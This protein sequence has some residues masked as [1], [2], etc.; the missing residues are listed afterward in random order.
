MLAAEAASATRQHGT[1]VQ[2]FWV[3]CHGIAAGI[4]FRR[5]SSFREKCWEIRLHRHLTQLPFL[6]ILWPNFFGNPTKEPLYFIC[7]ETSFRQFNYD[8]DPNQVCAVSAL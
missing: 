8:V 7:P 3:H 4:R 1:A 2:H 5:E 6:S